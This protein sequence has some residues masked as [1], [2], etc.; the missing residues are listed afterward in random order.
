[1]QS[2]SPCPALLSSPSLEWMRDP[3]FVPQPYAKSSIFIHSA[4]CS[5][6]AFPTFFCCCLFVFQDRVSLCSPGCPGT[7]SVDQAGLKLRNLPASV[8]QVLGLK[9]CATIAWPSP[10]FFCF[11]LFFETGFLYSPG[12]PGTHF[13]DQAGLRTQ[14]STCLCLP[15]AGIKSMRRHARLLSIFLIL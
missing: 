13:V 5:V 14:K 15:S 10:S 1:M 9:V 11:V 2:N 12:C 8:C 7:H 4:I 3:V 6:R